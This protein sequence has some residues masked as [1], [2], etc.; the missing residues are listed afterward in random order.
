MAEEDE[1]E[2]GAGSRQGVL[3]LLSHLLVTDSR[4]SPSPVGIHSCGTDLAFQQKGAG[5]RTNP[6]LT[7]TPNFL[8][9]SK[10]KHY[11]TYMVVS[12]ET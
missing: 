7:D 12:L 6:P 8:Q 10:W 11:T 1:G 2:E 4:D 9:P 3:L 5:Q